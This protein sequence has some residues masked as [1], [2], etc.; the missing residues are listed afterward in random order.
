MGG[1]APGR[2]AG[3]SYLVRLCSRH[4]GAAR[5]IAFAQTMGGKEWGVSYFL[6][7]FGAPVGVCVRLS[8]PLLNLVRSAVFVGSFSS[9]TYSAKWISI[10]SRNLLTLITT[11]VM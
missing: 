10:L 2:E 5:A 6:C 9:R 11:I 7:R 3:K 8:H 1:R 4:R